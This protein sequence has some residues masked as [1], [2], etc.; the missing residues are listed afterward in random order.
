MVGF[1]EGVFSMMILELWLGTIIVV[2][3]AL[4]ALVR[5][6]IP[7]GIAAVIF[8]LIV[9]VMYF[10][11]MAFVASSNDDPDW[12]S[13][14]SGWRQAAAAWVGVSIVAGAGLSWLL[15]RNSQRVWDQL[16]TGRNQ[17]R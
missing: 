12:Q 15:A 3:L 16:G 7:F 9:A 11:W 1:A 14:L 10:P 5:L 13:L 17:N 2:G 8:D 6:S 4:T